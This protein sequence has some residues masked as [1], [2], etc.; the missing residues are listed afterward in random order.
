MKLRSQNSELV[1][2]V[3][4]RLNRIQAGRSRSRIAAR[5]QADDEGKAN[6]AGDEPERQREQIAGRPPWLCMYTFAPKLIT[7]PT[8]HPNATPATPPIHPMTEASTRK[9]RR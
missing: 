9:M 4:Q 6:R 7:R 8:S 5:D 3:A 2:V 1:L